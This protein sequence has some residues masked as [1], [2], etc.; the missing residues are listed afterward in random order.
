[1]PH[2]HVNDLEIEYDSFGDATS[3]PLLLVMGLAYQMIDWDDALCAMIAD[4]GFWVVRFDNRDAGLST[5]LDRLG[6]PDL[7]AVITGSQAPPYTLDDMAGDAVGLLDVLTIRKAHIVGISMGGMIA[8]LIAIHYPERVLSLTSIMSNVG[9]PRAIQPD[10]RL[11]PALLQPPGPTREERIVQALANRR[12]INGTTPPFD[13]DDA[14]RKAERAVDRCYHP[15]GVTR[16]L[17]AIVSAPDRTPALATLRMP[18]LVVHGEKDPLVPPGNAQQTASAIPN[19]RLMMVPNMGHNIPARVWPQVVD[20]IVT[21]TRE[22]S[23]V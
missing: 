6:N 1:M 15:E 20:A 17:A 14:R 12:L 4:R 3:A 16:Q 2:A 7:M 21:I 22:T 13:E 9:G 19:A 23:S 8:Q 10:P 5:K 18:G 11:L